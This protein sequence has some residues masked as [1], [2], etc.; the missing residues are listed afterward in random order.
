MATFRIAVLPGDGIGP[1]VT[2]EAVRALEAVGR[3]FGHTFR[4]TY[5]TVGGA[6][7][8]RFGTALRP[9]TLEACRKSDAV[10][11][12]A[13][14]GPQ[15]DDPSAPVHPEDAILGLRKGLGLFAN[16]RP[17]KAFAFLA[18]ASTLRPEVL[19]GVDLMVVRELTGGL[20]FGRPQRRWSNRQGRQA[21]DTLRYSEQEI[22]RILR[23]GFE[24][25]Q[26]RRWWTP[27]PCT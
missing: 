1:E 24:L 13:V 5:D 20:Y 6:A 4:L 2:A 15:W 11:F 26:G 25:A 16:L 3:R 17:V 14:G 8:D 9:Q 23:V 22:R 21:V 19:A 27:A 12:G 18:G 10:L 7:I